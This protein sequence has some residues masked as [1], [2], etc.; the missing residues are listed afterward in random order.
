MLDSRPSEKV[1]GSCEGASGPNT[2][3]GDALHQ[4]CRYDA[5]L[6][7][8]P[9]AQATQPPLPRNCEEMSRFSRAMRVWGD[10]VP[11]PATGLDAFAS[12]ARLQF[13]G[14]AFIEVARR[15]FRTVQDID[16]VCLTEALREAAGVGPKTDLIQDMLAS[17]W[18]EE[19]LADGRRALRALPPDAEPPSTDDTGG[20]I[21]L[22]P[23]DS[24]PTHPCRVVASYD[25]EVVFPAGYQSCVS[26]N[27]IKI[28]NLSR[29]SSD[30]RPDDTTDNATDHTPTGTAATPMDDPPPKETPR[31][32]ET[33]PLPP[34]EP[35]APPQPP[36]VAAAATPTHPPA[37][38]AA[39]RSGGG[40]DPPTTPDIHTPAPQ[41]EARRDPPMSPTAAGSDPPP[42]AMSRRAAPRR[43]WGDY[44]TDDDGGGDDDDADPHAHAAASV[45]PGRPKA[46]ASP[47]PPRR[48][49]R[50]RPRG[51]AR[52][53][54]VH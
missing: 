17:S 35:P 44:S 16:Q 34:E 30:T 42:P 32:P 12:D 54:V 19:L 18:G 25:T 27:Q 41:A 23:P 29:R 26:A 50:V 20:V 2:I 33:P 7:G 51:R 1:V 13:Y 52:H 49:R 8:R 10:R 45:A 38:A 6:K 53:A 9:P 48:N 37:P 36:P 14:G 4:T 11:S 22:R 15:V 3:V 21:A 28:N 43:L 39:T 40:A 5:W 24:S 31:S 47:Q 46:K